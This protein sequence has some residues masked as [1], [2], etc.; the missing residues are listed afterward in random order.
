MADKVIVERL[1]LLIAWSWANAIM[2][3]TEEPPTPEQIPIIERALARIEA[4]LGVK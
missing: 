4:A 1:D 2:D 3:P